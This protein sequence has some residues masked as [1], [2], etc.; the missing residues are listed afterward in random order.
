MKGQGSFFFFLLLEPVGPA[1]GGCPL[2][3]AETLAG[4]GMEFRGSEPQCRAPR[5]TE[6]V[7]R[8][9]PRR[10]EGAS[11]GAQPSDAAAAAPAP[12]DEMWDASPA[13]TGRRE[14][15]SHG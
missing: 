9:G 4:E 8:W 7:A 10:R 6:Q 15:G 3:L 1:T 5:V 2:P 14:V 12:P 13:A 11:Q